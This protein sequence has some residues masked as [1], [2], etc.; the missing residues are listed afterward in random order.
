M[1]SSLRPPS[2]GGSDHRSP[3]PSGAPLLRAHPCQENKQ[4]NK[5]MTPSLTL[6]LV[7]NTWLSGRGSCQELLL[8]HFTKLLLLHRCVW[9]SIKAP[10]AAQ[11]LPRMQRWVS[12]V[13]FEIKFCFQS[14]EHGA[15][16][17][18]GRSGLQVST[19]ELRLWSSILKRV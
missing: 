11:K 3:Q 2:P 10:P 4:T 17:A 8:S 19:D 15:Q 12:S 5:Q 9:T 6:L 1:T 7:K 13:A 16:R 18:F 14:F